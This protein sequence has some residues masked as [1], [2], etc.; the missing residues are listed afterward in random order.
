M[1]TADINYC[2]IQV[3]CNRQ[4][5]LLKVSNEQTST[6][7]QLS[8]CVIYS[9]IT[10]LQNTFYVALPGIYVH[11]FHLCVFLLGVS[12]H[13]T[14]SNPQFIELKLEIIKDIFI[15]VRIR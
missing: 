13:H 9:S 3:T 8:W 14:S 7:E 15:K 12:Y 6:E 2:P 4:L 10:T 1:N 11:F 5:D